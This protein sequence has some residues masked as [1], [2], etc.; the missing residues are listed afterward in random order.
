MISPYIL[1]THPETN[2]VV[3]FPL[4]SPHPHIHFSSA[5]NCMFWFSLKSKS[6][7]F[8]I[9]WIHILNTSQTASPNCYTK[10]LS[11]LAC[12]ILPQVQHLSGKST[13]YVIRLVLRLN[14]TYSISEIAWLWRNGLNYLFFFLFN[15]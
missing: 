4:P 9:P 7:S 12:L 13:E 6:L 3:N 5:I 8:L 11:H 10:S 15:L 2:S 14:P 1:L